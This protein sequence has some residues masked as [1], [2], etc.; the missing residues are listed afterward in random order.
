MI[1]QCPASVQ[2]S[3]GAFVQLST[4]VNVSSSI[5]R[6][7]DSP[8]GCV[9]IARNRTVQTS[10]A[11]ALRRTAN[12]C[13]SPRIVRTTSGGRRSRRAATKAPDRFQDKFAFDRFGVRVPALLV[14]PWVERRVLSTEF[15]HTSLLKYLTEKWKLNPLTERVKQAN[16]FSD[17][18]RTSGSP[19]ADCPNEIP[20][21]PLTAQ[22]GPM[23]V[24]DEELAEPLNELQKALLAF[25]KHLAQRTAMPGPASLGIPSPEGGTLAEFQRAKQH[26]E[27]FLSQQKAMIQGDQ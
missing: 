26:V 23:G 14:S 13:R 1:Q 21:P 22:A 6:G 25:S 16:K 19:R 7:N 17:A 10:R 24:T 15:D 3:P 18:I 5:A 2:R 27:A 9:R 20:A 4:C 12:T 11:A 8:G